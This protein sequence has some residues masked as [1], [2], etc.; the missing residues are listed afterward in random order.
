MIKI[1]ENPIYRSNLLII[2]FLMIVIGDAL[3][4]IFFQ[5]DT[6]NPSK[7][8]KAFLL[9]PL[10]YL[11]LKSNKKFLI[12][13]LIAIVLFIV[14]SIS[15]SI[16]RL[17]TNI[18][19]FF[20]YY[21]F[22]LFFLSFQNSNLERTS[23]VLEIVFLLHASVIIIATIF[24][25]HFLKTYSS[26]E[27]LGYL[28]FF[29]SQNEF[30]YVMIAGVVFF[31]G[32]LQ[33]ISLIG[34]LKLLLMVIGALLLGT[35]SVLLFVLL[36]SFYL[37]FTRFKLK[38][39]IPIVAI[40]IAN[41]FLFW[42]AI[43]TFLKIHYN[44]LYELY[45]TEG[46]LSFISSK[47]SVFLWDRLSA[48]QEEFEFVNYLFGGYDTAILYEMSFMDLFYFFGLIGVILFGYIVYKFVL[49][50][51]LF[52]QFLAVY[53]VLVVGVSFVAGYL[54]ENASAQIYTLLVVLILSNNYSISS[55]TE[56]KVA[57]I[58]PKK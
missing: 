4:K 56:R 51:I 14:G 47:R 54:I 30:S 43:L 19:Q 39:S 46:F 10:I 44:T 34:V 22:I 45:K 23:K 8:I 21:F 26:S 55:E 33:H 11:S 5:S 13:F 12:F 40:L 28:S 41:V 9:V 35:K 24:D 25:I 2:F 20:E 18:P 32:K 48:H 16:Q 49:R 17:Y 38:Y 31:K 3:T 1:F 7:Y 50:A 42:N 15:I 6:P 52:N 37:L 27:R 58:N 29:S 53:T 36:F 57:N